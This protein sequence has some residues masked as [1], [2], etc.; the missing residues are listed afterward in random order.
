MQYCM[1]FVSRV[2]VV[3]VVACWLVLSL[4]LLRCSQL[5]WPLWCCDDV[6]AVVAVVAGASNICDVEM[7]LMLSLMRCRR[8]QLGWS[9]LQE[10]SS[11]WPFELLGQIQKYHLQD[12]SASH[13]FIFSWLTEIQKMSHLP[14]LWIFQQSVF[15]WILETSLLTHLWCFYQSE[16]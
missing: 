12:I 2:G 11:S 7:M 15:G 14:H 6:G 9:L 5:V 8:Y 1:Y 10:C 16:K 3:V 13:L 4:M